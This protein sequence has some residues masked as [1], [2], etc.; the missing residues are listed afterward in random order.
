MEN[1]YNL[2]LTEEQ[3]Q[4]I[5]AALENVPETDLTED[6]L[7]LLKNVIDIPVAKHMYFLNIYDIQRAYGG[8]EE[9]GWYYD[10]HECYESIGFYCDPQY[11]EKRFDRLIQEIL[12]WFEDFGLVED[13]D[14]DLVADDIY[15]KLCKYA[16]FAAYD[17]N[18]YGCGVR[19]EI[20]RSP[21]TNHNMKKPCFD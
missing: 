10:T 3:H 21:G 13:T 5:V 15:N 9:G 4:I 18:N 2:T 8:P 14:S 11:A 17:I 6:I 1:N 19:I 12:S 20:S 16:C 7:R